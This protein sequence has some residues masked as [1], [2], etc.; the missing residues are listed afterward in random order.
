MKAKRNLILCDL[1]LCGCSFSIAAFI[2]VIKLF[3]V[4]NE[5]SPYSLVTKIII[6]LALFI[7]IFIYCFFLM[8]ILIPYNY[9]EKNI[10]SS[11]PK[12]DE[13]DIN[14]PHFTWEW[15]CVDGNFW[16]TNSEILETPYGEWKFQR[17]KVFG[18]CRLLDPR[19]IMRCYGT[20]R[21]VFEEFR[22]VKAIYSQYN[23]I[24]H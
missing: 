4:G 20:R 11:L 14:H 7:G 8:P 12:P 16:W 6:A 13:I 23:Q 18:N 3:N 24:K 22:K 1:T 21:E 17:N 2:Y 10:E 19:A 15:K 9:K 5:F